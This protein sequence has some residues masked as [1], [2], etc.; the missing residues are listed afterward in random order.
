MKTGISR[1]MHGY[2]EID[3]MDQVTVRS[4]VARLTRLFDRAVRNNTANN[5]D[6]YMGNQTGGTQDVKLRQSIA[7]PSPAIAIIP[8]QDG[9][10]AVSV[11]PVPVPEDPDA[12]PAT[13]VVVKKD[14]DDDKKV[15]KKATDVQKSVTIGDGTASGSKTDDAHGSASSSDT[16]TPSDSKTSETGENK[17]EENELVKDDKGKAPVKEGN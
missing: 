4:E 7:I 3:T 11:A 8:P 13:L 5:P 2:D 9:G 1:N 6:I 10:D 16:K 14:D 17:E 15:E 12:S